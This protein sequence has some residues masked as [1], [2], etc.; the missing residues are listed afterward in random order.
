MNLYI[1]TPF[2]KSKCRYC[3]LKSAAVVQSE[4]PTDF[5]ELI[6]REFVMRTATGAEGGGRRECTTIY[7]GGGTPAMLGTEGFAALVDALRESGMETAAGCEWTVELNP[8]PQLCGSFFLDSLHRIGVDRVSIGAQS[9]DDAVLKRAGRIH[10]AEDAKAAVARAR[11]AGFGNVGID[12]IAGLPGDTETTWN[13]TLESALALETDHISVY[14]LIVEEGTPLCSAIASGEETAPTD[15]ELLER[16][17]QADERLAAAGYLRYEISNYARP[18]HEC[19]HNLACWHGEDYLGIGPG[20]SSR[21]GLERRTNSE[22]WR[23]WREAL[24]EGRPPPAEVETVSPAEDA[25]ERFV[26]ALRLAEGVSPL[27]FAAHHQAAAPL[28]E[29][30]IAALQGMEG[31]GVTRSIGTG[32]WRLTARGREVADSAIERLLVAAPVGT[33]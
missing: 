11:C 3:A 4:I 31:I 12:L 30:W 9:L 1:H 21:I 25:E 24:L 22:D 19:R 33:E 5:G 6:A 20:A 7:C 32:R 10:T 29:H 15:D 23:V 26:Y 2:C 17:A 27:E 13:A 14:S 16:I 28:L 8:V 18:G